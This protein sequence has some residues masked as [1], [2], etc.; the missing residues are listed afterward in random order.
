MDT[1]PNVVMEGTDQ[2]KREN[3]KL[4][5]TVTKVYNSLLPI[6]THENFTATFHNLKKR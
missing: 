3:A 4:F 2:L 6:T 1:A 5:C